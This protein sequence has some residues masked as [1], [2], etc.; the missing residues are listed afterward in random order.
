ML[1]SFIGGGRTF[2]G[3]LKSDGC[4]SK[5]FYG[6]EEESATDLEKKIELEPLRSEV[7]P[8]VEPAPCKIDIDKEAFA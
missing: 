8:D 1:N 2:F 7:S 5:F 3:I 4:L 6:N